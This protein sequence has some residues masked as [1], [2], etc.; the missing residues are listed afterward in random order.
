[1][2][3]LWKRVKFARTG[4]NWSCTA[5]IVA[6]ML[7]RT[8]VGVTAVMQGASHL[9]NLDPLTTATVIPGALAVASGSA[10]LV[11]FFTPGAGA[12]AGLSSLYIALWWMPLPAS[13]LFLDRMAAVFI[14]TDAAVVVLLGPGALSVDARLFG[15]REIIIPHDS[16]HARP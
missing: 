3:V 5:S 14:A 1:M 12:A 7:L 11:G 4:L 2:S 10:L 15:R 9:A 13:G 8:V 6:Y 16:H